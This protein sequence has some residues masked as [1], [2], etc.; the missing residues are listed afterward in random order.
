MFRIV[1]KSNVKPYCE[2][3]EYSVL[4]LKCEPVKCGFMRRGKV[5]LTFINP[6]IYFFGFINEQSHMA[7]SALPMHNAI[8]NEDSFLKSRQLNIL[9]SYCT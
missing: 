1:L 6:A 2:Q 8:D 7:I 5:P 3:S 9:H 4:A